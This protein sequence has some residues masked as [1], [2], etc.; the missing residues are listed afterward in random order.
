MELNATLQRAHPRRGGVVWLSWVL[1]T[2]PHAVAPSGN[3]RLHA[4]LLSLFKLG[5]QKKPTVTCGAMTGVKKI[6]FSDIIVA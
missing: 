1:R 6:L 5:K 2:H 4:C 3:S